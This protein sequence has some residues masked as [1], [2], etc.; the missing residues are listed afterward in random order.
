[1][2]LIR[3]DAAA[4]GFLYRALWL[5]LALWILLLVQTSFLPHIPFFGA[6]PD[7]VLVLLVVTARETDERFGGVVGLV[8][9]ILTFMMGDVGVA[10]CI[11]FYT[12]IGFATGLL[13]RRL[14]GKNYP[15]YLIFAA[16]AALCKFLF[17]LFMCLVFSANAKLGEAILH[18]LLPEFAITVIAA[19]ILYKPLRAFVR[20]TERRD[21]A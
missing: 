17:G 15:S 21:A 11:L 6:V 16:S 1:M 13:A 18:S 10:F 8:G 14:L 20:R 5:A 2:R 19:A 3:L 7:L 12:A 4:R 9:G